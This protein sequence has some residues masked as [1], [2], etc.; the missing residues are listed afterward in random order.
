MSFPIALGLTLALISAG[1]A[2]TGW[3][4]TAAVLTLLLFTVLVMRDRLS[5]ARENTDVRPSPTDTSHDAEQELKAFLSELMP[6]WCSSIGQVRELA[7]DN[8]TGLVDRFA[9]LIDELDRSLTIESGKQ[10][11]VVLLQETRERL[12]AV[13]TE[14][15]GSRCEKE[16]LIQSIGSLDSYTEELQDMS[17]SVRTIADQTNLLALNAAIEAARAGAAGRGFAVVADEVRSLS[18]SSGETGARIAGKAESINQAI[19]EAIAAAT[20]LRE[21]DETNLRSLE[22]TVSSVFEDFERAVGVM[23]ASSDEIL[24]NTAMVQQTVRDIIVS[25]QFQDRI[26]QILEHVQSDIERLGDQLKSEDGTLDRKNWLSRFKASFTTVE[27]RTG[28]SVSTSVDSDDVT[29]F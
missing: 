26:E 10:S 15:S 6:A 23:A 9:G 16:G 22:Q 18:R 14:F 8:I 24:Q 29:F 17:S 13:S 20:R 2:V 21:T 1:A 19:V 12:E 28:R 27:E 3:P 7:A 25:L 5:P 4:A 11:T